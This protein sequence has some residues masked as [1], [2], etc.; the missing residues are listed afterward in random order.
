MTQI[1]QQSRGHL[2]RISPGLLGLVGALQ[3]VF[4]LGYNFVVK[5]LAPPFHVRE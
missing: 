4:E 1:V 3:G 2:L 5:G